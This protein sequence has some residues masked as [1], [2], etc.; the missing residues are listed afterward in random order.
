MARKDHRRDNM[1]EDLLDN[2]R[3][4]TCGNQMER[5]YHEPNETEDLLVS[6]MGL[7]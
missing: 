5:L 4:D 1:K 2:D 6:L 7:V 3:L